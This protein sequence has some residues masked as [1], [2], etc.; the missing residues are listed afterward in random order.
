VIIG[1]HSGD[2]RMDAAIA[3]IED[4]LQQPLRVSDMAQIVNLSPS[5]FTRL[6]RAA[7]GASPARYIQVRRLERARLLIERT[8]LSVKEVMHNVGY[9]DPSHFTRDFAREYGVPPSRLRT[10]PPCET[11]DVQRGS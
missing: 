2:P 5:R 7:T 3:Y 1:M 11:A 4:R 8:F 10:R 9:N 6:F